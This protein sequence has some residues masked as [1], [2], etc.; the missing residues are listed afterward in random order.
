MYGINY[1][2]IVWMLV[3]YIILFKNRIDNDLV[4]AGYI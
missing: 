3:V 4:R 2:L 1:L